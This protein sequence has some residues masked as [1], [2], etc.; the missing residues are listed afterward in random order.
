MRGIDVDPAAVEVAR[1]N[2]RALGLEVS[3][4]V[5]DLLDGQEFDAILANL[6]YVP[7]AASL[8]PDV[9]RHEPAGALFSGADGLD[10]VRRLIARL[11]AHR[12]LPLMVALEIGPE[13]AQTVAGLLRGAGFDRGPGASRP[14]RP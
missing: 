8:P 9:A 12:P 14:G 2:A 5:A 1:G 11:A 7:E 3:F 10:L 13:Q 4:A 6:P